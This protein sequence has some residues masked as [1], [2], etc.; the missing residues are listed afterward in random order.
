VDL[1]LQKLF[2]FL[3]LATPDDAFL[4]SQVVHVGEIFQDGPDL[5]RTD[6]SR[7]IYLQDYLNVAML[8]SLT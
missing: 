8:V 4:A 7:Y 6:K 3:F 1:N 2:S 5:R